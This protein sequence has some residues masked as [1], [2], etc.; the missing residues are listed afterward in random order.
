M[1]S[2]RGPLLRGA[3]IDINIRPRLPDLRKSVNLKYVKLGYHIVISHA[4]YL[5]MV[6]VILTVFAEVGRLQSHHDIVDLWR[7]FEFNLVS[8]LVTSGAL[9]F[10]ATLYYM[11]RPRPVYLVD[12]ACYKPDDKCKIPAEDFIAKSIATNAFS[13]ESIEL[14]RK[15]PKSP[16]SQDLNMKRSC[17]IRICLFDFLGSGDRTACDFPHL[18]IGICCCAQVLE[19]SGLGDETY[20]PPALIQDSPPN[21]TMAKARAEARASCL[22]CWTNFSKQPA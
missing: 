13:P 1:E 22:A 21:P 19:R 2:L 15:V 5:L 20:L 12:Y 11:R 8:V 17:D 16:I 18:L 7:Q 10:G 14:Q 4:M 9:V 6:P 3:S